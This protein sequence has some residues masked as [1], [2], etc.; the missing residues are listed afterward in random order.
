[1]AAGASG[2]TIEKRRLLGKAEKDEKYVSRAREVCRMTVP[3]DKVEEINKALKEAGATD[4]G[5]QAMVYSYPID[6]AFTYM[7]RK[8]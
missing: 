6:K 4:E 3:A 2:A 5:S 7:K 8:A 1:M